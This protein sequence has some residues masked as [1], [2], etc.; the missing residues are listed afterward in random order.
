MIKRDLFLL[1]RGVLGETGGET[2]IKEWGDQFQ[3]NA[4]KAGLSCMASKMALRTFKLTLKSVRIF[5]SNVFSD[6]N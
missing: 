3:G 2:D 1:P 4:L 5:I 6:K